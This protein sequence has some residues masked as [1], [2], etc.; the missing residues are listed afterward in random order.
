MQFIKQH[1]WYIPQQ[2][3]RRCSELQSAPPFSSEQSV[4]NFISCKLAIHVSLDGGSIF[5]D[6]Y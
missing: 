5:N 1:L 3:K 4:F 6:I 2:M